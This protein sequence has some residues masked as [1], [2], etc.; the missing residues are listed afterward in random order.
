MLHDIVIKNEEDCIIVCDDDV[1]YGPHLVA[2][3]C[4]AAVRFPDYAISIL[5]WTPGPSLSTKWSG[6]TV[7]AKFVSIAQGFAGYLVKPKFLVHSAIL[8]YS[9]TPK[10]CKITDDIWISSHLALH[11]VKILRLPFSFRTIPWPSKSSRINAIHLREN[12][13]THEADK[14]TLNYF[15][16]TY[17]LFKH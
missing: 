16:N 17:G 9:N 11:N 7:K 8:D 13:K 5:G 10:E 14:V 6:V 15:A 2:N 1:I 3:L 4:Q 12:A